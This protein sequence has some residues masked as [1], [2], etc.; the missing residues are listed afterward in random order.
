M[1][2]SREGYE[3]VVPLLIEYGAQLDLQNDVRDAIFS[4]SRISKNN[5]FHDCAT[6]VEQ[7]DIVLPCCKNIMRYMFL[8]TSGWNNGAYD[9]R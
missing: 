8:G 1:M 6:F 4:H 7:Q 9:G 2:A 3:S 5:D